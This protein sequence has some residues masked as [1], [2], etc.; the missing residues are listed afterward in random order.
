[1]IYEDSLNWHLEAYIVD[2]GPGHK[3]HQSRNDK[4][5]QKHL[6]ISN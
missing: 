5:G 2:E 3:I 4:R 1:M 6:V